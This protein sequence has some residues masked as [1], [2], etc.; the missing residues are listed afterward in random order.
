MLAPILVSSVM[1]ISGAVG[2]MVDGW[3]R[4]TCV[5]V[6]SIVDGGVRVTCVVVACIVDSGVRVTCVIV[7]C[8]VDG[9]VTLLAPALLTRTTP[10]SMSYHG[11]FVCKYI[12]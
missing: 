7:G 12:N 6:G 9:G 3:I 8:I 1:S 11:N 4:V 5:V 2:F 10:T